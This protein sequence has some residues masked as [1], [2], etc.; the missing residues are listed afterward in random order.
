[1]RRLKTL[2][3]DAAAKSAVAR[4]ASMKQ[5]GDMISFGLLCFEA[6]RWAAINEASTAHVESLLVGEPD[7]FVTRLKDRLLG[8]ATGLV[9]APKAK[10]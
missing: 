10:R 8:R 9:R 1:M 4:A 2:H 5:D 6:G 7:W 3:R